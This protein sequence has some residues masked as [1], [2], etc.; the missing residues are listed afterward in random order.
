MGLSAGSFPEGGRAPGRHSCEQEGVAGSGAGGPASDQG[1][2][3][4]VGDRRGER[5][6][7]HGCRVQGLG[8]DL[9]SAALCPQTHP[10][11][12]HRP[13]CPGW[14]CLLCLPMGVPPLGLLCLHIPTLPLPSPPPGAP[15]AAAPQ[16][17]RPPT[18]A[19]QTPYCRAWRQRSV[20]RE[21]GRAG[22]GRLSGALG[23]PRLGRGWART[24]PGQVD[25]TGL[26]QPVLSAVAE[27]HP[28]GVLA[29][30]GGPAWGRSD[31]G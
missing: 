15:P 17:Q 5:R 27:E 20:E 22:Q 26:V 9:P 6:G 25:D 18:W 3:V 13:R 14:P 2:G 31:R 11:S 1:L 19:R 23:P 29:H 24:G 21:R 12:V 4:S 8:P 7:S 16:G 10:E 30:L 28:E